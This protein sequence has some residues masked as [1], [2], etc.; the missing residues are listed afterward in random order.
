MTACGRSTYTYWKSGNW[1]YFSYLIGVF[2]TFLGWTFMAFLWRAEWMLGVVTT[3]KMSLQSWDELIH[4]CGNPWR[5][6]KL[7]QAQA[8]YSESA[9]ARESATITCV[10]QRLQGRQGA[11]ESRM[12]KKNRQEKSLLGC[13]EWKWLAGGCW[14]QAN[15]KQGS[16]CDYQVCMF[17]FCV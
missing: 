11:R 13:P 12:V 2:Y 4:W 3:A 9:V 6:P 1:C 10:W 15:H 17:G 16:L 7:E 14:R 5:P 8:L